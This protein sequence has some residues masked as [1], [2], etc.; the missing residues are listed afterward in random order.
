MSG[1]LSTDLMALSIPAPTITLMVR[2]RVAK[3]VKGF[4]ESLNAYNDLDFLVKVSQRYEIAAL[5]RVVAIQHVGHGHGR[6]NIDSESVLI[7]KANYIRQ[8]MCRYSS[9]L[10]RSPTTKARVFLHLARNEMLAGNA[11]SGLSALCKAVKLDPLRTCS[12]IAT[13]GFSEM[14]GYVVRRVGR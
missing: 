13:R 10:S 3:E 11:R 5:P 14:A 8:H 7:E 9:R 4:D 1:D 2:T 6:M 12:L